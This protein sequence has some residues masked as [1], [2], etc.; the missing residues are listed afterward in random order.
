MQTRNYLAYALTIFSLS[1]LPAYSQQDAPPPPDSNP[2]GGWRRVGQGTPVDSRPLDSQQDYPRDTQQDYPRDSQRD[3]PR[4]SQRDY[5]QRDYSRDSQ[6]P[7]DAQ[8]SPEPERPMDGPPPPAQLTLA[9]GSWITVRVN[10]PLSSDR[11][12]PGD[13]FTATLAQPLIA[14]GFVI[15]RRGQTVAGRVAEAIKAGHVK[16]TSRLGLQLTE[17]S[18]VDGQ[19]IPLRTQLVDRRGDTSIGRDVG[20][21]ATTTGVG[22]AIGAAADGGF[23]AGMGA[24]AGAGASIIGVLVTRGRA[25]EVYPEMTLTFRLEAPVS[26]STERSEQAFQTVGQED[27][28]QR[29]LDRQRQPQLRPRPSL[30]GGG[31]YG[32][33]YYGPGYGPYLYSPFFYGPSISFYAGRGFYGRGFYGR[34]YGRR[35]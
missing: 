33:G 5:P 29:G 17:L 8:R 21:V 11:N 20:A 27:Y 2:S 26:I 4:S 10:Q 23:G 3:Y 22:A 25:T 19:Q 34:G 14:N 6:R 12:Q 15:A 13:S 28:E 24:I 31:Y 9:A 1:A 18:I 35:W 7:V 16:G 32:P 30:Y